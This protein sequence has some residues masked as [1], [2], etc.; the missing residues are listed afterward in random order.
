ME[1]QPKSYEQKDTAL[2]GIDAIALSYPHYYSTQVEW[3]EAYNA[4]IYIHDDDKEWVTR[5][6][7]RIVFWSGE[8]L[9]LNDG[10]TLYRLGGHFSGGTVLLWDNETA[11]DGVLLTGDIIQVRPQLGELHVQL[12]Q[13]DSI[14]R[15]KG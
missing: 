10:L 2:G 12:S 8:Y 7:D 5:P 6:S 4:P 14:A 1:K 13:S 11:T 3:A 9:E 15:S